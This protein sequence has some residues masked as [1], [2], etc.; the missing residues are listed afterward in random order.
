M[1]CRY[2]GHIY[3]YT[4]TYMDRLTTELSLGMRNNQV[5]Y[6]QF[7]FIV[8]FSCNYKYVFSITLKYVLPFA[9]VNTANSSHLQKCINL[10]LSITPES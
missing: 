3:A 7:T 4:Q 8:W 10:N 2:V 1:V 6:S 9:Q 5:I